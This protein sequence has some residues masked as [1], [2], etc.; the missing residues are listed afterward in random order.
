MT[1]MIPIPSAT[2]FK[3]CFLFPLSGTIFMK[4][5]DIYLV[6]VLVS[7]FQIQTLIELLIIQKVILLAE[8]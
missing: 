8:A 6:F 4:S 3:Y 1:K 5:S 7:D 2:S